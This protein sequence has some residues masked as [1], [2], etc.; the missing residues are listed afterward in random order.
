[1]NRIEFN[2]ESEFSIVWMISA[3][4]LRYIS[5]PVFVVYDC[6]AP[7]VLIRERDHSH[8]A[9]DWEVVLLFLY[10]YAYIIVEIISMYM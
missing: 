8:S 2:P 3:V 6:S 1:V 5:D 9:A 10:M 7:Y 4:G